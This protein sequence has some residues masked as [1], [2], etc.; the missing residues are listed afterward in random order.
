MSRPGHVERSC[1]LTL[2]DSYVRVNL[3]EI[4]DLDMIHLGGQ[5]RSPEEPFNGQERLKDIIVEIMKVVKCKMYL[6]LS[7]DLRLL[8]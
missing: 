5:L 4:A 6:Q 2:P 1:F 3:G 8:Y 7:H